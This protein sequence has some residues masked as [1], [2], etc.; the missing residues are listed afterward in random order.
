MSPSILLRGLAAAALAASVIVAG[1]TTANAAPAAPSGSHVHRA[2][3]TPT[4]GHLACLAEVVVPSASAQRRAAAATAATAIEGLRPADIASAYRLSGGTTGTVAIV[5]AYD[6]PKLESDLAVYRK[7]WGLP[8]CTTANGCFRKVN[9]RGSKTGLPE[10]DADWGLEEAL[11]VDAVSAGCPGCRILVVET[12]DNSTDALGAG[13]NTAV[14]LGAQ[15]VSNSYGG[16]EV[17]GVQATG[18]KYYTHPG[19]AILASSGDNGFP[20]ASSPATFTSVLAVGGT[21]LAKTS[22]GRGWQETAWAFG[23]SGCSAYIAKPAWQPAS[24]CPMRAS[25]DL[26]AVA[27]PDTGLAMYDTFGTS[28]YTDTGWIEV[29]GTSL[30]APL[31]SAMLVR[32]GKAASYSTA[33]RAYQRIASFRDVLSGSNGTCGGDTL[34]TAKK[35]WDAP[36]GVGTPYSLSSF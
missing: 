26:S 18:K 19:V 9:Q 23:G 12:D 24:H 30:S 33:Q 1:A 3:A 25:A 11:D 28:D 16:P 22:T 14:R 36:T 29:G 34:C 10:Q 6:N 4:R 2:C 17:T 32:S 27:D 5:D 31:V 7:Q 15:A 13:V 35:G 20:A 21:T 8:A